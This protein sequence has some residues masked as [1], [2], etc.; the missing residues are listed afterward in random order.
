MANLVALP[1]RSCAVVLGVEVPTLIFSIAEAVAALGESEAAVFVPGFINGRYMRGVWLLPH[2]ELGAPRFQIADGLHEKLPQKELLGQL[3]TLRHATMKLA[4]QVAELRAGS[5]PKLAPRD[6][7]RTICVDFDGVIHS[8]S[9]GFKGPG[10]IPDQPVAGA[11]GWLVRMI[12][13]DRFRVC[14]YS[15]RSKFPEGVEAMR[16]WLTQWTTRYLMALMTLAPP[17][18]PEGSVSDRA[19]EL[20]SE[21]E[22]PTQKPAAF[23][24]IDDRALCFEGTFPSPDEILSFRPWYR[25]KGAISGVMALS[26][27][28]R[29]AIAASDNDG[30]SAGDAIQ[31]ML[32]IL[33][34]ES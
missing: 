11:I 21:L 16:H 32:T 33:R 28:I 27:M 25:R 34:G 23:L 17:G 22:F 5:E 10:T 19:I 1:P 29:R 31:D 6:G 9:S 30:G 26:D 2:P 8:Y 15:S 18:V 13:D 14:I 24:T 12:N 7:R 3:R 4:N 20:L